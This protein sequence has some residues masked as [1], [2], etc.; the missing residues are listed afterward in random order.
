MFNALSGVFMFKKFLVLA[1]SCGLVGGA[2]AHHE[3]EVVDIAAAQKKKLVDFL[4]WDLRNT[5]TKVQ[6]FKCVAA[7]GA[8]TTAIS[9]S[10]VAM[11]NYFVKDGGMNMNNL[12]YLI[13]MCM[14]GPVLLYG[15]CPASDL[16]S[17]ENSIKHEIKRLG[18]ENEPEF[19]DYL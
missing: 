13:G 15:L 2:Y 10:F 5:H 3:P 14:G 1:L 7:L 12:Q 18:L 9:W 17:H 19:K 4:Y 6:I 8:I 16:E 11:S